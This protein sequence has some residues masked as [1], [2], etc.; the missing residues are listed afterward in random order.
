[1]PLTC[2]AANSGNR[3]STRFSEVNIVCQVQELLTLR[4]TSR[5]GL[6]IPSLGSPQSRR[7]SRTAEIA[8]VEVDRLLDSFWASTCRELYGDYRPANRPTPAPPQQII[9][10]QFIPLKVDCSLIS[11]P[12]TP[13]LGLSRVNYSYKL[14]VTYKDALGAICRTEIF[15]GPL[16]AAFLVVTGPGASC[17]AELQVFVLDTQIVRGNP[18]LHA[19]PIPLSPAAALLVQKFSDRARRSNW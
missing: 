14:I 11:L 3:F 18:A 8:W 7:P 9:S 10:C 19:R 12:L 13:E 16:A 1:M 4:V 15:N 5:T 2:I 17:H 6:L